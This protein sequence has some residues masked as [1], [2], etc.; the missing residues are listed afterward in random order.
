[1]LVGGSAAAAA[2]EENSGG[3]YSSFVHPGVRSLTASP[4]K[5]LTVRLLPAFDMSL[6]L[7]DEGFQTGYASYRSE[8]VPPQESGEPG[9]TDWF[10]PVMGYTYFGHGRERFLS[11]LTGTIYYPAG[12]DPV[13]DTWKY[14][15][16]FV[17]DPYI[18]SLAL[19]KTIEEGGREKKL[20]PYL[21]KTPRQFALMNALVQDEKV[22][23]QWNNIVLVVTSSS[24]TDLIKELNRLTPRSD[25][26]VITPEWP[27]YYYGDVTHPEYGPVIRITEKQ[28]DNYKTAGFYLEQAKDPAAHN[29]KRMPITEE[30]LKGR[31]RIF[32]TQKVTAL[33][34]TS[35]Q[36]QLILDYLV[37]DGIIPL[38][39]LDAACSRYGKINEDLRTTERKWFEK[40][41]DAS[42][43]SLGGGKL[44]VSKPSAK[45]NPTN[46]TS[47]Q[48]PAV[49]ALKQSA[50]KQAVE[51]DIPY[52][53]KKE[54][55]SETPLF[56]GGDAS[57]ANVSPATGDNSDAEK[58]KEYTQKILSGNT[59]T[60]EEL[61]DMSALSAKVNQNKG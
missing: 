1:M 39:I 31:Y 24:L 8:D 17:T 55:K 46:S 50:T 36:Y 27:D 7:E 61:A 26:T 58:L 37:S 49:S 9:F 54:E 40:D 53:S 19:G 41:E 22:V 3:G 14:I 60:P 25:S 13:R 32:D 35:E 29:M 28:I 23:D 6:S 33:A 4:K 59:L 11:G 21:Q 34:D 57:V 51:E 42:E 18:K 20:P 56:N 12:K 38:H 48:A 5:A 15:N 43:G 45:P 47:S 44:G 10:Y 16:E 30:Q 2:A 52:E